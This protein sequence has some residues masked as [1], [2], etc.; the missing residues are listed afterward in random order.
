MRTIAFTCIAA[1]CLSALLSCGNLERGRPR[2]TIDDIVRSPS[3]YADSLVTVTELTVLDAQTVMN[4]S[5]SVVTDASGESMVMLDSRPH[6]RG[7]RL[8]SVSG[9]YQV[10]LSYGG[11]SC[12]VFV[13]EDLKQDMVDQLSG[14]PFLIGAE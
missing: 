9:R 5:R 13:S 10:L 12:E 14:S 8:G 1:A 6:V 4:L 3:I 2:T 11:L 7:E